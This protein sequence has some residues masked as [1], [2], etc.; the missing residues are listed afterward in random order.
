MNTTTANKFIVD[1]FCYPTP[2][3]QKPL[4]PA[5]SGICYVLFVSDLAFALDSSTAVE[6]ARI[7]LMDF[8]SCS[9]DPDL[10]CV[11]SKIVR[12]VIAGNCMDEGA[13]DREKE[14]GSSGRRRR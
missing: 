3:P 13:A 4:V 14:T 8:L 6:Q 11:A 2:C 9:M 7:N 1:D 10:N 5:G 12:L